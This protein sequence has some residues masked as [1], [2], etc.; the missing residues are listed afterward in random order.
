[1][2]LKGVILLDVKNIAR[3][4]K[5]ERNEED[6]KHENGIDLFDVKKRILVV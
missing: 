3:L 4:G 5:E 1:M 2:Y 6:K